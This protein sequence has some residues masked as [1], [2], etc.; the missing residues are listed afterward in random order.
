MGQIK[1]EII[2]VGTELLLGQIANTNAQWISQQLA[3]SGIDVYYH[4][5]VGDNLTRVYEQFLQASKRSDVIIVTGGLGPTDDDLT[6]EAFQRLTKLEMVEHKA[7]MEKIASFFRKQHNNMTPNNK[8]QART[9][10]GAEVIKNNVGMAPG[11]IVIHQGKTWV[12][13]PGVPKEMKPMVTNHVLPALTKRTG[14]F[15]IIRSTMLQFIGIGESRLE[16]ELK[17]IIDQQSNPTIAPL[18]QDN[19][20]A[21][22]ITAKA[23][24]SK[25][26]EQL[27][28]QTKTQI[29]DGVG[30]YCYGVD[31]ETLEEKVFQLLKEK[32]WTLAAAESLTGGMF[33]DKLVA[34]A[35][36]S[37][38]F[39]GGIVCYDTK[40]K[41]NVLHISPATIREKGTVSE[42]CALEMAENVRK[43]LD[44]TVGISFTGVAG[45]D[46]IEGQQAGTVY[47]AIITKNGDEQA[48][49]FTFAGDRAAVRR[50]AVIKGY[51]ILFNYLK[52]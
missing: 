52:L 9:F 26:A 40:V 19:G 49:K 38:V 33:S 44:S 46:T 23:D 29:L 1:S 15:S 47:I 50:K 7:S 4:S 11:M 2:A 48:E 20:V 14:E 3:L 41:E 28:Q 42:A 37:A 24:T 8:K 31:N 10:A 51:E 5:V 21:I 32:D 45:P 36:A 43:L 25:K 39:S 22:R 27:I 6:R 16:H 12:F 35:G 34:I 13:L 30:Q 17:P 18:A